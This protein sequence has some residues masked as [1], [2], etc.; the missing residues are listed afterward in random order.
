MLDDAWEVAGSMD[1]REIIA[2]SD[3]MVPLKYGHTTAAQR[4]QHRANEKRD[5]LRIYARQKRL[6]AIHRRYSPRHV[7][8]N[9]PDNPLMPSTFVIQPVKAHHDD[10]DPAHRGNDREEE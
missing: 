1:Q 2:I 3:G 5:R 4:A 8:A 6:E 10:D 9:D 7:L